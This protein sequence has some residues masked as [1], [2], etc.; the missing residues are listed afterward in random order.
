LP[1]RDFSLG[2]SPLFD[3]SACARIFSPFNEQE[4]MFSPDGR[5]IYRNDD[6]IEDQI[7]LDRLN[8]VIDWFDELRRV[9]PTN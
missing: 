7:S 8:V 1:G 3:F 9:A 5:W 4:A 2:V 6:K